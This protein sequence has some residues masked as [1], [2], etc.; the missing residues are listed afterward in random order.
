MLKRAVWKGGKERVN[1]DAS[2][3]EEPKAWHYQG[4]SC[5]ISLHYSD[6]V[7]GLPLSHS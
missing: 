7:T 3:K 1:A 5:G 2:E 4:R 6:F